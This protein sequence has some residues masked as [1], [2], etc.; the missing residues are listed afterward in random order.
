MTVKAINLVMAFKRLFKDPSNITSKYI[1]NNV[2][3]ECLEDLGN[4]Y[5]VLHKL[6]FDLQ[7]NVRI[8][9][10]SRKEDQEKLNLVLVIIS[11]FVDIGTF[12]TKGF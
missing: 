5:W 3:T 10:V 7:V 11:F 2:L 6:L 1:S 9:F 8:L 4:F 12:G